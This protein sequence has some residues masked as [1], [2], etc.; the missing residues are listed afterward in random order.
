[1]CS[2]LSAGVGVEFVQ[3][4]HVPYHAV[5]AVTGVA[6]YPTVFV[7]LEIIARTTQSASR[8]LEVLHLFNPLA[9]LAV[10]QDAA[11]GAFSIPALL[12]MLG[13]AVSC[14]KAVAQTHWVYHASALWAIVFMLA[15][16]AQLVNAAGRMVD[17]GET[18][19]GTG[20]ATST[21]AVLGEKGQQEGQDGTDQHGQG[22]GR[23]EVQ[24]KQQQQ[25][26]QQQ[27]QVAWR[28]LE[29]AA[30]Q[31]LRETCPSLSL[32]DGP[33]QQSL[34]LKCELR[35]QFWCFL[36][37]GLHLVCQAAGC[38]TVLACSGRPMDSVV[39]HLWK[40]EEMLQRTLAKA[41]GV[42]GDHSG[43]V[44]Q[45]VEELQESGAESL[46]CFARMV[47]SMVPVGF[48]CNNPDCRELGGLS[49]LGLVQGPKGARGLCGGCGLA[50]YCSRECQEKVWGAHRNVC[51]EPW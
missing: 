39:S 13:A 16:T 50:C 24:S 34:E 14:S 28:R 43:A 12:P 1:M 19:A 46:G 33:Q 31:W 30:Q 45:S 21:Y 10:S 2:L 42:L 20:T 35:E 8:R 9:K 48:C 38:C 18:T 4:S 27:Q 26:Q 51:K 40:M 7:I 29:A 11:L 41:A 32:D 17:D 15:G 37:A 49:E 22:G 36:W 23:L 3:L 5:S 44:L 47:L 6:P 25:Q